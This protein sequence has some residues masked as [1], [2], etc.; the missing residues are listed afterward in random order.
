PVPTTPSVKLDKS[1]PGAGIAN[2]VDDIVHTPEQAAQNGVNA[3]GRGIEH[4]GNEIGMMWA[5]AK[6][7]LIDK[8]HAFLDWLIAMLKQYALLAAAAL[9][10]V[11]LLAAAI[12]VYVPKMI[13][14][15]FLRKPRAQKRK[16]RH[17]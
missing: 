14:S 11:M 3:V 16:I 15:L 8:A 1:V 12:V 9:F 2:R 17:A 10:A 4:L 13:A 5:R 6:Q 7:K